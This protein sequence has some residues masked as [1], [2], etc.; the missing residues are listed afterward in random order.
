VSHATHSPLV[1]TVHYSDEVENEAPSSSVA[2][3]YPRVSLLSSS[4]EVQ[5]FQRAPNREFTPSR[6]LSDSGPSSER[7]PEP[8]ST[9]FG[10]P[11]SYTSGGQ[12]DSASEG[13]VRQRSNTIGVDPRPS[14]YQPS[15]PSWS[16][17]A[18]ALNWP[19][20][21]RTG[22]IGAY[23]NGTRE[24]SYQY[25][26]SS[27]VLQD[28]PTVV[29]G[30]DAPSWNEHNHQSNDFREVG[31]L[32]QQIGSSSNRPFHHPSLSPSPMSPSALEHNYNNY[33]QQS[34][35]YGM[36]PPVDMLTSNESLAG[37]PTSPTLHTPYS[38]APSYTLA[39]ATAQNRYDRREVNH[40]I[41]RS[42]QY[43][44]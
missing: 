2:H 32:T 15:M 13:V 31:R 39:T 7:H 30:Q 33:S 36:A 12:T 19:Q 42:H 29:H 5:G 17:P 34:S 38:S 23:G 21:T 25:N 16:T 4:N 44:G 24:Q 27:R 40:R 20:I 28:E 11:A 10:H 9:F 3:Q 14:V 6:R 8:L 18:N 22:E 41:V 37:Q 26:T 1:L 35:L 43:A